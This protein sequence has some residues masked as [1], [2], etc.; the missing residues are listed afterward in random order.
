MPIES[1]IIETHNLTVIYHKK[2]VLW[3]V[4][5]TLPEGKIIGIIG[6]NGA[7]KSTLLKS[8]MGI[9]PA[10]S[11]YARLFNQPLEE[12]RKR[13][14]YVPQ[15]QSVDWD[16]PATVLDVVLTGCYNKR[17]MFKRLSSD[18]YA[19]AKESLNKVGMLEFANRQIAQL[20]GG[21]QQR[22][23]LARALAQE[24]D[25]YLMDEPFAGVDASTENAIIRILQEMKAAGKT[26]VVV[27]HDLQTVQEYF[28]WLVL[29]N[30]HLVG[31]GP[32][33][34]VFTEELLRKTYGGKL[35]VLNKVG[36]L[37]KENDFPIRENKQDR[38]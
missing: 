33:E 4:D 16:F 21:Q 25:L 29:I 34:D 28:D 22:V 32:T 18:D 19:L 17:G 2:P 23:F 30:G 7:G 24:A 31:S 8:I 1:P 20:S 6:P 10:T 37:L 26:M 27:H 38:I 14:S 3:N 9:V 15:R 36:Q 35:T 5:F 11:G 13:V 12:V